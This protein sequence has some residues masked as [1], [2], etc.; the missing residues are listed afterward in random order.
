M[1]L[2]Q[3]EEFGLHAV[4]SMGG[5][6]ALSLDDGTNISGTKFPNDFLVKNF[7]F[8]PKKLVIHCRPYICLSMLS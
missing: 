6:L 5:D 1:G 4:V 3:L 7:H 8:T 2:G